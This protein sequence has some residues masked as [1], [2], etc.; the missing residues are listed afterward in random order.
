MLF[1]SIRQKLKSIP[2]VIINIGQPISHRIDFITSGIRA[3]IA[4][5]IFGD[6]LNVLR[7]KANEAQRLIKDVRGIADLQMEQQLLIP[8]IHVR[9]DRDKA[10]QHG[11]M[12]GEAANHAELALQGQTVTSIIDGNRL[13]DVILRLNDTAREDKESIG[14]IP[15][16]TLREI[17]RASCRERVSTSV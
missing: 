1:R 15:F 4:V 7:A 3:E 5:K 12:I 6:D 11:V 8:Q 13:F 16:E 10:K 2:G 9:F 14:K 17:G